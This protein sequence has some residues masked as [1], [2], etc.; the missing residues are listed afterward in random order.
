MAAEQA[1]CLTLSD[2]RSQPLDTHHNIRVVADQLLNQIMST[3]QYSLRST[4][5]L[6]VVKNYF[7][8]KISIRVSLFDDRVNF[9]VLL[10]ACVVQ[11]VVSIIVTD[12][13]PITNTEYNYSYDVINPSTGD[14]K[15]LYEVREGGIV[16]GS[17][18]LIDPDG[19]R[20]TVKYVAGPETGFNAVVHQEPANPIVINTPSTPRPI[21]TKRLTPIPCAHKL[22]PS[23]SYRPAA[24]K[25]NR[26]YF[27]PG[28]QVASD[29]PVF[30]NGEYF[31]ANNAH[32][33][34]RI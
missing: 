15:S 10:G 14:A 28:N 26:G 9:Q 20:R 8:S 21:L 13:P 24:K 19:T 23:A 22:L 25:P 16:R 4:C 1:A 18:S 5:R 11:G 12:Y 34:N 32:R 2:E 6:Y 3:L 17:Y 31:A 27:T 33:T 30:N 7:F 29:K